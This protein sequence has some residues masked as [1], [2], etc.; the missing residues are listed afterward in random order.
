MNCSALEYGNLWET[1]SIGFGEP[2]AT[3]NHS[4][5]T[6]GITFRGWPS[7]NGIN[8]VSYGCPL[9]RVEGDCHGESWRRRRDLNDARTSVSVGQGKQLRQECSSAGMQMESAGGENIQKAP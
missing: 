3:D 8:R 2:P 6:L 7:L 5:A 1:T 9:K 4:R